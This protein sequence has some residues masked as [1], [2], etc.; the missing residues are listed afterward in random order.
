MLVVPRSFT[1]LEGQYFLITN[2]DCLEELN[3]TCLDKNFV[4]IAEEIKSDDGKSAR[5]IISL[6]EMAPEPISIL[7]K[8]NAEQ[9]RKLYVI[10]INS[11]GKLV[12]KYDG[13]IIKSYG[14]SI[15]SYFPRT[16]NKNDIN[17]VKQ[18]LVMIVIRVGLARRL[19]K[20]SKF[21]QKGEA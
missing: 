19:S 15:K 7:G 1:D 17:A 6:I 5:Y 11:M 10:Y 21:K 13:K 8:L 20:K 16:S 18:A 2:T 14:D 9:V 12:M 3:F 4:G